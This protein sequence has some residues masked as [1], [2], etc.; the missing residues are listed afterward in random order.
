MKKSVLQMLLI[1]SITVHKL[2]NERKVHFQ[3]SGAE[4]IFLSQEDSR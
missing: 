1:P 4:E 3:V 2:P